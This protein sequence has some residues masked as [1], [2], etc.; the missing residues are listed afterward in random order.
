M[1]RFFSGID[2]DPQAILQTTFSE[3]Y[4]GL[5]TLEKIS[6]FS[7]CEH[8][9]LPFYGFV[10][11]GYIPN[12]KIAGLS[13]FVR[14]IDVLSKR[15]QLQER[16]TEQIVNLIDLVLSPEGV[17]VIISAEHMCMSLRGVKKL[18]QL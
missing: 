12:G 11:I 6:F 17:A 5:V 18:G 10:S 14:L 1:K 4:S 15:P 3:E 9:L 13:K 16:L 2:I 7:M 8:H